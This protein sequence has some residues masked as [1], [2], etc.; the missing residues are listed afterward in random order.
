[1]VLSKTPGVVMKH[2][3]LSESDKIVTLFTEKYGKIQA[4]AH[5]ARKSASK[6]LSST[7]VFSYGEY[8]L[9]KGKSLYTIDQS[10]LV[11]SFQ[12]LLNDLYTLTYASYIMELSDMLAENEVPNTE[13]FALVLK[14]LYLFL[15]NNIDYELLIRTFELKAMSISGYMPNLDRCSICYKSSLSKYKFSSIHGGLICENCYNADKSCSDMDASTRNIMRF[16]LRS[17]ISKIGNIKISNTNKNEMRKIMKTYIK[18]HLDKEF[19]SLEFLNNIYQ[20]DNT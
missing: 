6:L 3:N 17:P 19:K 10:Q 9:Y 8:V 20:A 15:S 2:I 11:E 16:L 1:M 14:C 13:L 7:Q 4:V 12:G 18:Y 5:G